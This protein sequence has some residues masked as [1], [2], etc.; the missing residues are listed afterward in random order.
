MVLHIRNIVR[1]YFHFLRREKKVGADADHHRM[2][3]NTAK[4]LL[5]SSTEPSHIMAF[6]RTY[7]TII[8]IGIETLHEFFTLIMFIRINPFRKNTIDIAFRLCEHKAIICAIT[9]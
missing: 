4:R 1:P 7:N 6:C 3:L 5:H 8:G 2:S 9:D